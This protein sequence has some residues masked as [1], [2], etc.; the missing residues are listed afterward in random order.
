M[1]PIRLYSCTSLKFEQ[2]LLATD[3]LFARLYTPCDASINLR[4]VDAMECAD[5]P[6]Q[7]VFCG[8]HPAKVCRSLARIVHF[9]EEP[10]NG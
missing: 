8:I 6:I 1:P 7:R 9:C 3:Y 4:K 2:S 5:T 10:V